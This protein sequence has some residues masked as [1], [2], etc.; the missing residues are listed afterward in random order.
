[1]EVRI[2][3]LERADVRDTQWAR[4]AERAMIASVGMGVAYALKAWGML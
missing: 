4:W 2:E 3:V 1:M